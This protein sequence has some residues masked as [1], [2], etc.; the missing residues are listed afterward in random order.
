MVVPLRTFLTNCRLVDGTG[1]PAVERALLVLED[2]LIAYAGPAGAAAAPTPTAADRV[3]DLQ[4]YT[5][6]P[7]LCNVHCHMG[8]RLPFPPKGADPYPTGYRA[9]LNYRRA[10]EALMV[11]VTSL[12]VVGEPR[13]T[14]IDL[15]NAINRGMLF[16]PRLTVA[17]QALSA[18][19]GHGHTSVD[20]LEGSGADDF[21]RL[22]RE[23]LKA[24]ADLIKICMTGG[25]GTPGESVTEKQMADDE[26][27]AVVAVAQAK[28][29]YVT[30]HIG[31]DGPVRDAVR[32]G[33]ACLEHGYSFGEEA[34]AAMAA[35]GT[36]LVPT[37]AVT[38]ALGYMEAHGVPAF[39]LEKTRLAAAEHLASIRRAVRAGVRIAVGTDLLPSDPMDGT[40]ATV[41]EVEL[42]VKAGMTPLQAL[43]AA[44][45]SGARLCRLDGVT[46]SLTAGKEGDLIVVAGRPDERIEDL[47]NLR[48]VARSGY[49][50]WSS[51]PGFE[52]VR[53]SM[54]GGMKLEGGTFQKW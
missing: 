27:A 3:I 25:I 4:G 8:L 13:G 12:R 44:T 37:L 29:T 30:A 31:G 42:L 35:A 6:L 9:L 14:D 33:V 11:G 34:A 24:G 43:H 7:G 1:S 26:I 20:V 10:L 47:R 46:G 28:G 40:N 15:R 2:K 50:V 51:V 19:G 21:R 18:T 38:H 54:P 45:L 36:Y 17:G 41:R 48:L 39:M 22:A 32:L 53:L 49:L 52:L 16:G 5:A 23:Q